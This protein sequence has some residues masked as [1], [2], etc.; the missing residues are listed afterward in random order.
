MCC[1]PCH[2]GQD[3]TAT[4]TPWTYAE[5]NELF[6]V[7]VW[8]YSF[9]TGGGNIV[10]TAADVARFGAALFTPGLLPEEEL[11]LLQSTEWFGD[12]DETGRKFIYVSGA[13]PGLQ[14]G[15]AIIPDLGISAAVLS[16][17]WGLGSRSG[18]MTQLALELARL[19]G[20]ET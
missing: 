3:A 18:E 6:L 20:S 12:V 11:E 15:L 4:I 19:C 10:A 14:A 2:S 8:D 5:S 7:P 16:N 9:N 1:G 17:T 13:N